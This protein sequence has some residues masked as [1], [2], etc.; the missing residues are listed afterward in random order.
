MSRMGRGPPGPDRSTGRPV[1][2]SAIL[3]I[4]G[5]TA[6]AYSTV[7]DFARLRGWSTSVPFATAT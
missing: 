7:T 3:P 2:A 1:R 5:G 6:V 4:D